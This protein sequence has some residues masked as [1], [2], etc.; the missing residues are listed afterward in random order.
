MVKNKSV[1]QSSNKS[2][3]PGVYST[4]LI[5]GTPSFRSSITCR[6]HHISLGSW[7][8]AESAS[9]AYQFADMILQSSIWTL[10]DYNSTSPL[11]FCKCVPLVNLRDN[12]IYIS[13]PV[14]LEKKYFK[15]Y[16]SSSEFFLF[17]TDDLFYYSSHKIMK[18]GRHLFTADYGSQVN[19]LNRYGIRSHAVCGRDYQY[20]NGDDHDLRYGNIVIYNRFHGVRQ[21][22]VNGIAHFKAVI[23]IKSD[24]VIGNFDTEVQAAIAYNKAAD[25]LHQKGITI[26]YSQN[27]IESISASEYADIYSKIDIS[28]AILDYN[29]IMKKK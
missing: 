22:P 11:P 26:K 27:Y 16:I 10:S 19:I 29:I 8:N 3:L 4:A 28:S 1:S 20:R 21:Y 6:R 13:S 23:H 15:Y 5:D 7:D 24:C 14:Y 2:I 25:I 12:G 18:R 17:D 9:I